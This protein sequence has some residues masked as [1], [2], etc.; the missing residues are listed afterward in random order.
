M[1]G[2]GVSVV[3]LVWE[4]ERTYPDP[5][6]D[7]SVEVAFTSPA[8]RRVE[9]PAFWDGDRRWRVR[10]P[11]DEAGVW[12]YRVTASRRDDAGLHDRYGRCR[13]SAESA[14]PPAVTVDGRCL[15]D[16]AG[17]PWLLLG[18][19]SWDLLGSA[20]DD[21]WPRYVGVRR[22]QGFTALQCLL[23]PS[24]G[25]GAPRP[26]ERVGGGLR[27]LPARLE[28]L[29]RRLELL[30]RNGLVPVL[31]LFPAG[32]PD[33]LGNTLTEAEAIRLGRY[34]AA[35]F[36]AVN[37]LWL[38]AVGADCAGGPGQRWARIGHAIFGG[39]A[40]PAGILPRRGQVPSADLTGGPWVRFIALAG[41]VPGG[42][43]PDWPARPLLEL[44][45]SP[46]GA[47][48]GAEAFRAEIYRALLGLV[49]AGIG[50]AASPGDGP[51]QTAGTRVVSHLRGLL[52]DIPWAE[53]RPA[54][55]AVR[56]V[57]PGPGAVAA[58][59]RDGR[60]LLVYVPEGARLSLAPGT[61]RRRSTARWFSPASGSW[62]A[63]GPGTPS[64]PCD[65]RDWLL[66]MRDAP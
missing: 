9:A 40:A 25:S 31:A 59:T 27:P 36:G 16:Q 58:R 48:D 61:I 65:T 18:D 37:P 22:L 5:L 26:V 17:H 62:C 57:G 45:T 1:R 33:D 11:L 41:P 14:A 7:I 52:A 15:R 12:L 43:L 44:E 49:A 47:Q 6:R 66:H 24:V 63:A 34:L 46:A 35:R 29:E 60:H 51:V 39:G 23:L 42:D 4:S 55:D 28:R 8:G 64:T 50:F 20:G 30:V 13:V 32:A 19:A 56:S 2:P 53:L 54:P 38:V 21:V 10:A 3:D